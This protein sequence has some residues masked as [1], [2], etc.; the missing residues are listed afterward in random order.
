MDVKSPS[1]PSR[2][3][4]PGPV[5]LDEEGGAWTPSVCLFVVRVTPRPGL[6]ILSPPPLQALDSTSKLSKALAPT[7]ERPEIGDVALCRNCQA[8]CG[9]L[10][11]ELVGC[12]LRL[13][14]VLRDQNAMVRPTTKRNLTE[15]HGSEKEY[16][17]KEVG[18]GS[19]PGDLV[20]GRTSPLFRKLTPMRPSSICHRKRGRMETRGSAVSQDRP[21]SLW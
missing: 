16:A 15:R 3:E 14:R 9:T 17:S 20:R 4:F 2:M 19:P 10:S 18:P 7:K 11:D 13:R 1:T 21:E 5:P 12:P 8:I 6:R